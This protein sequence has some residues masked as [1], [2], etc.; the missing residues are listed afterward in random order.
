MTCWPVC[1][2]HQH[3]LK[4]SASTPISLPIFTAGRYYC[5]CLLHG[6][7]QHLISCRG[8]QR[9]WL[10]SGPSTDEQPA[11][12]NKNVKDKSKFSEFYVTGHLWTRISPSHP[13]VNSSLLT[14]MF[15]RS[16]SELNLQ[17]SFTYT[18]SPPRISLKSNVT[19]TSPSSSSTWPS[20][21][22]IVWLQ[23]KLFLIYHAWR[24]F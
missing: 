24:T 3:L 5:N 8:H 21:L 16:T 10:G 14:I 11:G 4:Q 23:E 9:S 12:T 1:W 15:Y 20:S 22:T 2:K 19:W 13:E 7:F 18:K 6:E 17:R